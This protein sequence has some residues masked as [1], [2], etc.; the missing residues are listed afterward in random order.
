VLAAHSW[1]P[2]E[3]EQ[4][5]EQVRGRMAVATADSEPLRSQT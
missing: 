4:A 1:R 5:I 3:M 2:D